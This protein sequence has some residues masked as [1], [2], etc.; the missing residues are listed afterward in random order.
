MQINLKQAMLTSVSIAFLSV[1]A[2]FVGASPAAAGPLAVTP[3]ADVAPASV[4]QTVQHRRGVRATRAGY[5]HRA[6]RRHAVHY[7]RPYYRGRYAHRRA[8]VNPLFPVAAL[9]LFAGALGAAVGGPAT[10]Y[11]DPAYYSWGYGGCGGYGYAAPIIRLTRQAITRV[12]RRV[13]SRLCWRVLPCLSW[14][15][16][17]LSYALSA[18]AH[19][20]I[21]Q[22]RRASISW[23]RAPTFAQ[24][25]A[26]TA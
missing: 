10:Y 23:D 16:R 15:A 13:L 1:S 7:G 18:P 20:A 19:G 26:C 9:G 17:R 2:A 5:R 14:S 8:Y 12:S 3:R 22:S 4:T 24:P 21:A 25:I 6:V 11:C